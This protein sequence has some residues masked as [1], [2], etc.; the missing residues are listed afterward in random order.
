MRSLTMKVIH[1]LYENINKTNN[2]IGL[3]CRSFICMGED[4]F[5]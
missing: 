4:M 2:M 1:I 3:I 5:F